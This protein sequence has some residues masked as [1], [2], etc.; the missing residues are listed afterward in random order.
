MS[1]LII[2]AGFLSMHSCNS[3]L[4]EDVRQA[5]NNI[6][7]EVD[8]N[9]DIRPI[10]TDRCYPCHGPDE[11][12]REAGLRLDQQSAA[13]TRLENSGGFAFKKGDLKQ[14]VAWQRIISDDPELMMPPPESNLTL[15]PHEKAKI[16]KWIEQGAPWKEHWAFIPPIEPDIPTNLPQ[17]WLRVNPIDHFIQAKLLAQNLTPSS[18]AD[19][20][21]LIRRVS[22][23]LT[24]LPPALSDVDAFMSDTSINAYEKLVDQL[25]DSEAHAERLAMEWLD[26]SRYA[27][28]MAC[29]QMA[30]VSCGDGEIG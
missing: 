17:E 2:L 11:Q 3:P 14:S 12:K 25:L 18:R 15:E 5:Y 1:A 7:G 10:L 8:F 6:P 30:C 28:S 23:D 13:F 27:D 20:E 24:G 16:A 4:P 29:M 21:R 22:F 26:V 9:F 19:K